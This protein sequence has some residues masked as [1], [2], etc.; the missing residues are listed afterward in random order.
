MEFPRL[1]LDVVIQG[2]LR[3][4]II[5]F[6][7]NK[8]IGW[9]RYTMTINLCTFDIMWFPILVKIFARVIVLM[10]IKTST[11]S[12]GLHEVSCFGLFCWTFS[13]LTSGTV[14]LPTCKFVV[15]GQCFEILSS[16]MQWFSLISSKTANLDFGLSLSILRANES[17]SQHANKRNF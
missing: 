11:S 12:G 9:Q 13:W 4:Y 8:I 5:S 6:I 10:L 7:V 2:S 1:S 14:L 17:C 15:V 16:S 3:M